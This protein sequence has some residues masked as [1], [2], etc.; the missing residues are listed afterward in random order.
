MPNEGTIPSEGSKSVCTYTLLSNGTELSRT[1]QVL[2][3]TVSKEV[4][5]IPTATIIIVDGEASKQTFAI[6]NTGDFEPGKEIEIK[7]GYSSAEDTIFKGLVIKHGIKVRKNSSVLV[8]ECKDKAVKMTVACKNKYFK[9]VKDSDVIEQLIDGYGLDKDVAATSLSH[10]ELVQYNTTDWDFLMC[11][12]DVNGLLCIPNDGKVTVAKPDFSSSSVLTVQFGST[13]HDLDAEIDARLQ[14]T[15]VKAT[16]WSQSDQDV[17][18][19]DAADPSVPETGN[20]TASTLANITGS[21]EFKLIHSGNLVEQELQQWA[22]A[23]LL[24]Q[25]MAKIRGRIT[26]DGTPAVTPGKMIH[27]DGVG[28]RFTGNIYVTAVRHEIQK[29]NWQT[30]MQFGI[31]PEWFA[32]SYEVEQPLAGALLPAIQGLQIGIV[33]KLENDPDGENRIQVRVPVI[34]TADDGIW[35]RVCTLDAGKNRGTFYLPEI[36]DEVIV[37]FINNDPRHA[38]ILGMVNSSKNPAALTAADKNDEKGYT[39]RSGMKMIFNDDK[40]SIDIETPAG[41]TFSISEDEKAIKM[42]D[43]NGNKFTMDKD[44]IK[45]ESVKDMVFKAQ[46]DMNVSGLNATMKADSQATFKGGSGAELSSGGSTAV[47]GSVVQIN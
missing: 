36:G 18:T 35:S 11:R 38:V 15:G 33:T 41:N 4:N 32:Q 22:N 6:S 24:K 5:R 12:A 40:K 45:L 30:S 46:N 2:S 34:D 8:V 13:V 39:S 23:K 47:K 28:D 20:L 10:K 17:D 27:I 26:T 9:D 16:G 42:V 43:Q 37:G 14:F 31:E 44:G 25:R 3:I 1:Y 19:I 29:G 21:D 7:A